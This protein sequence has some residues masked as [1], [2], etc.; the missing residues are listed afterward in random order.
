LLKHGPK[1][2]GG[3]SEWF[4]PT[5]LSISADRKTV[6]YSVTDNGEGDSETAEGTIRDPFA[7]VLVVPDVSTAP[8][9]VQAVAGDGAVAVSWTAPA[10]DNDSAI[11]SYTVTASPGSPAR[12]CTIAAPGTACKVD[13]LSNGTTYTFT[14]KALN[15]VG[16]SDD[17]VS[18]TATPQVITQPAL[19]LPGGGNASVT[20]GGGTPGCTLSSAQ[21][22]NNVPAGAP[23][24]ATFPYGVFRFEAT[25]CTGATLAVSVTYPTALAAGVQLLKHGP[26]TA[27]GAS[28]WFTPTTVSIS[29]DRKTVS[30]SVT[31]N[32]EGDSDTTV[33]TIRDPFA[34][35]QVPVAP[36]G[37]TSIPTLSEWGLLWMSLLAAAMGMWTVRRRSM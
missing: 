25:G 14:V 5:T 28:E 18:V 8:R 11:Q 24:R 37:A 20:I 15:G 3:A 31:D 1:T 30:Y 17:S 19:P 4:T 10:S 29:A 9:N 33:G 32:G 23:A 6:S 27:G 34:P 16:L 22:D 7:P 21:F 2:F 13:G 36:A 35:M 26:K 12:T